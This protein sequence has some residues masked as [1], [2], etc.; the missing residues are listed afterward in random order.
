MKRTIALLTSVVTAASCAL[1]FTSCGD[2]RLYMPDLSGIDYTKAVEQFDFLE[3]QITAEAQ[4]ST[5]IKGKIMEQSIRPGAKIS[6][7]QNVQL[8]ISSGE[9]N[10]H[11]YKDGVDTGETLPATTSTTTALT[12]TTSETTT[13]PATTTLGEGQFLMPNFR[14]VLLSDAVEEYGDR[15]NFQIREYSSDSD[16]EPGQ[17][18]RQDINEDTPCENGTTLYVTI[19]QGAFEGGYLE[20]QATTQ[21][22]TDEYGNPVYNNDAYTGDNYNYDNSYSYDNS[23]DNSYDYNYGYDDTY[24]GW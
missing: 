22:A 4:S 19:A 7:G 8:T 14:G 15:I 3:L 6:S 11:V 13:A 17:I 24:Y 2:D 10:P 18:I 12:T 1:A 20:Q 5:V 21:P 16:L 9:D 23:Y